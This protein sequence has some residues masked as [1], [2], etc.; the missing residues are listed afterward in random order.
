MDI[1]LRKKRWKWILF[2]VAILIIS[3]SWYYT[4]I[5]AEYTRQEERKNVEIWADAIQH[6]AELVNFTN[7]LFEQIKNEERKRVAFLA[8][9]QKRISTARP[10]EDLNFYLDIISENTTIPVVHTDNRNNII[11]VR[12][13]SFNMDTV[14]HLL[15]DL[16]EE[17]TYYPPVV[18]NY[19]A[20]KYYYLYYKDSNIF[21]ELKKALDNLISSF[22]SE[23]V[24]NSASVPVIITDSTKRNV[25]AYGNLPDSK[26][27]DS[28][29]IF[30]T[31]ETMEL[32]NRP[33]E[34]NLAG[35]G[36]RYIFYKDS[37]LLT[38]L[39]YYPFI[40]FAIF[41]IFL[42]IAYLLFST[43]RKSEQNQV[44]VGMAKETAHQLGTPLS[45]MVGWVELLKLKGLDDDTVREIEKDVL[46]LETIT[47]RFSKIGAAAR[48]EP[49]NIVQVVYDTVSY[50]K[51]RTSPKVQF[52]ITPDLSTNISVPINLHLFE[53]VI[54]NLC[55]NAID[56]IAGNGTIHIEVTRDEKHVMIDISD[57][58]KGIQKSRFKTIFHPGYTS[59]IRGWGLGLTLSKRII[60]NYHR[61]KIFVK[62]SAIGKGTT[63]RVVLKK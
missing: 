15:G 62:S 33:I 10:D 21:S 20:D 36:L 56:A 42:F 6:K 49:F 38:Q 23:V 44:W 58:G 59:K 41:G 61:G 17:F 27:E 26:M 3:A 11:S 16:R 55:K 29:F 5:L 1:Y 52:E 54:E 60:D 30:R 9:A 2:I 57:S 22:F 48:L 12:N 14:K 35:T 25:I 34:V 43:A 47:D 19:L 13:V 4:N 28:T 51:S 46:R 63:F 40:M 37:F 53:W 32:Q 31:L 39:N 8:E 18:V 45:S 50:I 7:V 24:L